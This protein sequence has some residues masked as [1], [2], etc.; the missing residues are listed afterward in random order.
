M[1]HPLLQLQRATS[2]MTTDTPEC[3][4]EYC[5]FVENLISLSENDPIVKV[6]GSVFDESPSAIDMVEFGKSEVAAS[7]IE[8][9]F[10]EVFDE[11]Y[12][13]ERNFE[14]IQH[15]LK[16]ATKDEIEYEQKILENQSTLACLLKEREHALSDQFALMDK[17]SELENTSKKKPETQ[18]EMDEANEQL[19]DLEKEL[20]QSK[21]ELADW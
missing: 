14:S 9:E 20:M 12:L 16:S 4:S 18:T 7:R 11:L 21:L 6:D 13:R 10:E 19:A 2:M 3:V 8:A 17:V 1:R 5:E 15:E